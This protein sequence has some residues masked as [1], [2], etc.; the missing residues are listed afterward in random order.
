[1]PAKKAANDSTPAKKTPAKKAAATPAP[2]PAPASVAKKAVGDKPVSASAADKV[3]KILAAKKSAVFKK[4]AVSK[5]AAEDAD[6]RAIPAPSV[7]PAEPIEADAGDD[8]A[9]GG[10]L[11]RKNRN[12]PAIFKVP[13]RKTAPVMFTL[14]DVQEILKKRGAAKPS[15]GDAP[16]AG[17]S[18]ASG[19]SAAPSAAGAKPIVDAP[20]Q[21]TKRAAASLADILGF[22]GGPAR[23]SASPAAAKVERKVPDKWKKYYKALVDLRDSVRTELNEHSNDTL[24]RSQKEDTGDLATSA[25]SGSDNFDREFALSLLSTEQEALKEIQAAIDRIYSGTYG[26]CEITG[27]KIADERLEAVPFTRYSLEG[28]RQVEST[29]RRRVQRAGAFLNEG[30]NVSF[31]EEESES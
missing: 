1:M 27:Q 14:E 13:N 24:K 5:P 7:P 2:A 21:A 20:A 18:P 29:S 3:E 17:A 25:D 4:T 23:T 15:T 22:G 6:G 19:Q 30:E 9:G 11:R 31:G 12:T 26:V 16:E 10:G 8:K 28:Q